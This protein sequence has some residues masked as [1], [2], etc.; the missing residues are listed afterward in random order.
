MSLLSSSL[1]SMPSFLTLKCYLGSSF[2][3]IFKSPWEEREFAYLCRTWDIC[4]KWFLIYGRIL[5]SWNFLKHMS[6]SFCWRICERYHICC[7]RKRNRI[8]E[9][10]R[11]NWFTKWFYTCSPYIQGVM[12]T[13]L[14]SRAQQIALAHM[15]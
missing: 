15:A 3:C 14:L 4:N 2:D 1:V 13:Q 8:G 7:E 5:W 12:E 9:N 11:R 10:Y 6:V